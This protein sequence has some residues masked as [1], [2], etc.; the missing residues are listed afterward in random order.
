MPYANGEPHLG[1]IASTYLPS[2]VYARFSRQKGY[3]VIF[4]CGTDDHGT[5]IQIAAESEGKDPREYVQYWRERWKEDLSKLGISFDTFEGTDT[6]ENNKLAQDFFERL[7]D[8]GFIYE[9]EITQYYCENDKRFLPD[10]Y[11]LG[12]CPHCGA[13]DQYADVCEGCGRVLGP[14]ELLSPV[15]SICRKP[16]SLGVSNHYIFALSKLSEQLAE[17][18]RANQEL[19]PGVKNYV[20]SWINEGLQD[21]DITRDITWGVPIPG[22]EG[23]QSLYG[24][25]ENHLGYIS[26][27]EKH[28]R[29]SGAS[30]IDHW[31]SSEI[32]HFIGKDIVYHHY[33]FLPAERLADGRYKLPDK[34]PTR[35]YLLLQGRKFSKSRGWYISL[36]DFLNDFPPDYLR[37]YLLSITSYSQA[38]VDFQWEQ[39][40]DKI[41][42]DLIASI[43]NLFFRVTKFLEVNYGSTVP[44]PSGW[45][46]EDDALKKEVAEA[47]DR[48]ERLLE[49]NQF[50]EALKLV[51]EF[52]HRL[53][54]YFQANEPWKDKES[55][56]RTLYS[57]VNCLRTVAILLHPFIPFSASAMWTALNA[58]GDIAENSFARARD[59]VIEP[60]HRLRPATIP[61]EKIERER[62]DRQLE[63]LSK[64]E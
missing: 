11:V 60:G 63:A 18:L 39:F 55:A 21:W 33:L 41:N 1:H 36:K 28:A 47:V 30:F 14:G 50:A 56:P 40:A 8:G 27:T 59:Y 42:N 38:D 10:R 35:G 3:D 25:F 54:Q 9:K 57:E 23:S 6:P 5:P 37:F 34:I 58:G 22:K 43:G 64:Q 52:S 49:A 20:L 15:C 48:Y 4:S 32:S 45:S 53:N 46:D 19:Q 12:T 62:V 17:W 29:R 31:N 26:I 16:A 61:Y 7:K 2:D 44:E 13:K 51:V 24:W